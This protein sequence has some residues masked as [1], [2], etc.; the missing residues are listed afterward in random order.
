VGRDLPAVAMLAVDGGPAT[1][2]LVVRVSGDRIDYFP[3]LQPT[4]AALAA[5]AFAQRQVG[6]VLSVRLRVPEPCDADAVA[7]RPGFGFRWFVPEVLRHRGIWRDVLLAS[8]AIQLLALGLP[9]MTQAIVDKVIVHRTESTLIALGT[10]LALFCL[11]SSVLTWLRQYLV[12]HTGTRID[13][14]LGAAVFRHLVELPPRYFQQRPTGVITARLH[15]V[16]QVRELLSSAAIALVLD[17]PF[18]SIC[19]A[20]MFCTRCRSR[21]W[22]WRSWRRSWSPALRSA[23]CSSRDS[24]ASFWPAHVRRH[25]SPSM[26]PA[27]KR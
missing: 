27:S 24:V 18:L 9:L 25:F 21:C 12:L 1:P 26:S 15:G 7:I 19:L 17:L 20:V 5:P 16:E 23:R 4:A 6:P 10:G 2:V 11:I 3:V 13:A 22:R 14:V 8:L